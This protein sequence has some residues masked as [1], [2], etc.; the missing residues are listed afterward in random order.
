MYQ[1]YNSFGDNVMERFSFGV[2]PEC[3]VYLPLT[4]YSGGL[5]VVGSKRSLAIK[6]RRKNQDPFFSLKSQFL[7]VVCGSKPP[8]SRFFSIAVP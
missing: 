3:F 2:R 8:F 7:E 6:S 4:S 5:R 1:R